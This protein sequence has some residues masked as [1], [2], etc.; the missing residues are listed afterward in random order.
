MRKFRILYRLASVNGPSPPTLTEV[1]ETETTEKA[2]EIANARKEILRMRV[3][4]IDEIYIDLVFK[5]F[6]EGVCQ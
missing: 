4:R 6:L 3:E 1:I 2:I 5:E